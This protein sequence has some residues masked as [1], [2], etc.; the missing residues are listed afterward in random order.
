M[1]VSEVLPPNSIGTSRK[2]KQMD[3]EVESTEKQQLGH[4]DT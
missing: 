1:A 2:R 4:W 3:Q